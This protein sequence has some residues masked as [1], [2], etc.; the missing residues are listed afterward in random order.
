MRKG[1][2]VVVNHQPAR[3]TAADER[4]SV[5]LLRR[6]I[7]VVEN[8]RQNVGNGMRPAER[9]DDP[10]L[11][12]RIFLLAGSM[13]DALLHRLCRRPERGVPPVGIGFQHFI[14]IKKRRVLAM[15]EELAVLGR[16]GPVH[17]PRRF[18]GGRIKARKSQ[19]VRYAAGNRGIL[20]RRN[21]A[22]Q[23]NDEPQAHL[24]R[25]VTVGRIKRVGVDERH[26]QIVHEAGIGVVRVQ[27]QHTAIDHA[28]IIAFPV[29]Q[30]PADESAHILDGI[31]LALGHGSIFG[32]RFPGAG[33]GG[34][35]VQ[36][37]APEHLFVLPLGRFPAPANGN[38]ELAVVLYL[39]S[40]SS[41][42][43]SINRIS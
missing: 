13:P 16:A 10:V 37:L 23:R 41:S 14:W 9:A 2:L 43:F 30:I 19:I 25:S 1:V 11:F 38:Q 22:R 3:G 28:G 39:H 20:V 42:I 36:K 32:H 34:E 17:E 29:F 12:S 7:L 8:M 26:V 35:L 24:F 21:R 6:R 18:E 27:A 40:E 31:T 4:I 15:K 5:V 33:R